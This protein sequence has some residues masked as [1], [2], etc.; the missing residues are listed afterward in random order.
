ARAM[1]FVAADQGLAR[2]KPGRKQL[3]DIEDLARYPSS[4]HRV[5]VAECGTCASLPNDPRPV[6]LSTNKC[7]L[8][9]FHSWLFE[10]EWLTSCPVHGVPFSRLGKR[11]PITR[12]PCRNHESG[13]E[14]GSRKTDKGTMSNP[15]PFFKAL[16]PIARFCYL[17]SGIVPANLLNSISGACALSNHDSHFA[18]DSIYANLT[19]TL[20]PKSWLLI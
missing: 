10:M 16:N 15:N 1:R 3:R 4:G 12:R 9:S 8:L 11:E 13:R 6:F 14:N 18:C 2:K 7:T 20:F 19:L 17:G 5:S